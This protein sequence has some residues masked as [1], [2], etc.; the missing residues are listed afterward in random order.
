MLLKSLNLLSARS[1]I[2]FPV[3]LTTLFFFYSPHVQSYWVAAEVLAQESP[4]VL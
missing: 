3:T 1:S 4:K 2:T